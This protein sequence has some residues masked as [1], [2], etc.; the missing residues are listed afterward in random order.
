MRKATISVRRWFYSIPPLE[1]YT[2]DLG[3][4]EACAPS[5]GKGL[6]MHLCAGR[7][8]LTLAHVL[9]DDV[10]RLLGHHSVQLHKLLVPQFLHDLG[11]L[12]EG[13]WR[14]RAWLQGFDGHSRGSVPGPCGGQGVQQA[15]SVKVSL[16]PS[17]G[18]PDG[19]A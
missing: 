8:S 2:L 4:W 12:Q 16:I 13:L 19:P 11:L 15:A 14:H 6:P 5:S 9:R 10:D 17:H 18:A 1:T 3:G 7:Q